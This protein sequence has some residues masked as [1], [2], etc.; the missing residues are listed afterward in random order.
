MTITVDEKLAAVREFWEWDQK[1]SP[2][3]EFAENM[4]ATFAEALKGWERSLR[5]PAAA[6]AL[7]RTYFAMRGQSEVELL[8]PWDEVHERDRTFWTAYLRE[9]RELDLGDS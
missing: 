4:D 2:Y 7:R 9:V 3:G 6:D 5:D 1:L 8:T